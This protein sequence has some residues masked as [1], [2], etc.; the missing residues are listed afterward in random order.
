MW[1]LTE[2]CR[3]RRRI[4]EYFSAAGATEKSI[5]LTVLEGELRF[6]RAILT[7]RNAAVTLIDGANEGYIIAS[8]GFERRGDSIVGSTGEY[9]EIYSRGSEA[10]VTLDGNGRMRIIV[11]ERIAM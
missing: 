9:A 4:P 6:D 1:I 3:K 8:P 10:A 5:K 11:P 2:M 7:G